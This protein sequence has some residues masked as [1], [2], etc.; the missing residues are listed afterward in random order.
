MTSDRPYR[1]AMSAEDALVELRAS[2]GTQFDPRVVDGF[3]AVLGTESP[4]LAGG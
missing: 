3:I 2:A 4:H 1:T